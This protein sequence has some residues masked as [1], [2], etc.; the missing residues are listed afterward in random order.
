VVGVA[1]DVLPLLPPRQR[2]ALS[3][4]VAA[5][6]DE[7]RQRRPRQPPRRPTAAAAVRAPRPPPERQRQLEEGAD[8][9]QVRVPPPRRERPQRGQRAVV[10][11]P[12]GPLPAQG[13]AISA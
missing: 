5:G 7:L 2:H 4:L 13:A 12:A 6:A 8:G 11:E 1:D 3:E 9:L 10:E